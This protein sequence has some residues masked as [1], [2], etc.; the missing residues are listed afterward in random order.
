M[1]I[2]FSTLGC[3]DWKWENIIATAKDMGYDGVEVRGVG[4]KLYA[5]DISAFSQE[6]ISKTKDKLK[7]LNV[8]I[9]SLASHCYIFDKINI[10]TVMTEAYAY[11]DLAERLDVKYIRVLADKDPQPSENIDDD[12]VATNLSKLADYALN[13]NVKI[14]VETNGVY[15]CSDRL[16]KLVETVNKPSVAV[17]WDINHPYRYFNEDPAETY[18]KLKKYIEYVHVKDSAKQPDGRI[19]YKM[20]GKGDLPV[21]AVLKILKENNYNGFITLEWVKRWYSELEEPG[22]VF[23][24]YA[25]YIKRQWRNI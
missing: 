20:M 19:A 18:S 17:L 16:L 11:I 9:S 2:A 14:L 8:E 24:Q 4:S 23:M 1:K 12:F 5:P 22:I 10:D 15:A 25:S 7:T 13:K 21:E 3:P 6:N